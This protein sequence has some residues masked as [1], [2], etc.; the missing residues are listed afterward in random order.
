MLA[1]AIVPIITLPLVRELQRLDCA[2]FGLAE[3][4]YGL[5]DEVVG[6]DLIP[7]LV[8]ADRASR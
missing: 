2:G 8:P 3:R 7:F 6:H 5:R 1:L 4:N